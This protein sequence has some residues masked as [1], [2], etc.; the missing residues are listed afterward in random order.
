MARSTFS[1]VSSVTYFVLLMTW[2]T[3]AVETP[4][5]RA[6]SLMRILWG[7]HRPTACNSTSTF[8]LPVHPS[9]PFVTKG[10][11]DLRYV[12]VNSEFHKA[13]RSSYRVNSILSLKRVRLT[14]EAQRAQRGRRE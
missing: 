2:E 13:R 3:V 8:R 1:R 4:A 6:T 11:D 7:T 14:A 10:V 9:P 5:S 12:T